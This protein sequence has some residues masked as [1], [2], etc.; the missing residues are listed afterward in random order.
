MA[1]Q[2]LNDCDAFCAVF[3]LEDFGRLAERHLQE[4]SRTAE[5]EANGTALLEGGFPNTL[6]SEFVKGVCRWGGYTG[7]AARVLRDNTLSDI[8]E[9]LQSA[10]NALTVGRFHHAAALSKVNGLKHLGGVS[11][12]SKH[13]RFLRPDLCPVMDSVIREALPYAHNPLG[14]AEFA[15]DCMALAHEL[16]KR[17]VPNPWKRDGCRWYPADVEAALYAHAKGWGNP[18]AERGNQARSKFGSD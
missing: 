6:L 12:A 16:G 9:A 14:Y 13:L 11:F 17:Q 3:P 10:C 1:L 5:L 4:V 2:I 7:I 15:R 18:S 8:R